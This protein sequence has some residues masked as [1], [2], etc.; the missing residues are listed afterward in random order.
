MRNH[1]HIVVY[2]AVSRHTKATDFFLLGRRQ[3]YTTVKWLRDHWKFQ[4]NQGRVTAPILSTNGLLAARYHTVYQF[5]RYRFICYPD[6]ILLQGFCD[7]RRKATVKNMPSKH[8]RD[9][10]TVKNVAPTCER[11]DELPRCEF[12]Q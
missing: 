1:F 3:L 5:S 4:Y 11:S 7:L 12:G 2:P 10:K 9:H 8:L 6:A